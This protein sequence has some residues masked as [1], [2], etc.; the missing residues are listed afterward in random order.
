MNTDKR[1]AWVLA[2]WLTALALLGVI[3]A[4]SLPNYYLAR[5]RSQAC[6]VQADLRR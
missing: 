4:I 1:K 3:A 6:Q 5:T 2:E